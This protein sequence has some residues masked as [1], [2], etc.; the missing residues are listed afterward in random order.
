MNKH[1][2]RTSEVAS[3]RRGFLKAGALTGAS[4]AAGATLG[5][6]N[7]MAE[8]KQAPVSGKLKITVYGLLIALNVCPEICV[9]L[10]SPS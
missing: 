10:S 8:D 3:S 5:Q 9:A 4:L 1:S 7:C 6:V 2:E